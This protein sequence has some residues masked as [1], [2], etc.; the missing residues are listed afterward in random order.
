MKKLSSKLKTPAFWLLFTAITAVIII[1]IQSAELI[2]R[3][4]DLNRFQ[5]NQEALMNDLQVS[6]TE[7]GHLTASIHALTLRRDELENLIPSYVREI[8]S[9][10]IRL[11]DAQSIAEIS[12]AA[13][14]EVLADMH[15]ATDDEDPISDIPDPVPSEPQEF[16]Y[17]DPWISI[18]GRLMDGKVMIAAS[19]RDSIT[20]IAHRQKRKCMFRRKG[21]I[22]KYDVKCKS[23]Y[24]SISD[25]D[26]IEL[27]E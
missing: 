21:A 18:K 24:T 9:L 1:G 16:T 13:K 26:Y 6:R 8:E 15:N 22:I 17:E 5:V 2:E 23:P 20:L 19:H 11:K 12:I 14:A 4:I 10:K 3:K 27:V 7:N 25:V